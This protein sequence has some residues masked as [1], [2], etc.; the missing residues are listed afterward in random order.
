MD[1]REFSSEFDILYNNISSNIAPGL[2]EYEKSVFLTQ[3]QEQLVIAIYNGQFNGE[4]FEITEETRSYIRPLIEKINA[5]PESVSSEFPDTWKH[6]TVDLKDNS[7]KIWFILFE[8]VKFGEGCPCTKDTSVI[9]KP[10]AYD[11]YWSTSR[12]PFRGPNENRVLRIDKGGSTLELVSEYTISE[13]SISFLR[14]PSPIILEQ[15]EDVTI[16]GKTEVS[17]SELP[18]NIHRQILLRAVQLAKSAWGQVQAQS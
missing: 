14:K 1:T 4:A 11:V 9:V 10:V 13:Y 15:L 5:T 8:S 16:D 18:E 3:A 7:D 12:N 2:T 17:T 6:Y